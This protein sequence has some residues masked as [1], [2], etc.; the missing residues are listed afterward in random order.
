MGHALRG[1]PSKARGQSMTV[2]H[3]I[4]AVIIGLN[5]LAGVRAFL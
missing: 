4:I 5:I 2:E 3:W 1:S